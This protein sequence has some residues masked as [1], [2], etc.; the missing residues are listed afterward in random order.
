MVIKNFHGCT[1]YYVNK[2]N[3]IL[4][5]STFFFSQAGEEAQIF[6]V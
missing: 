2:T 1:K 6:F 5:Q 4:K 3:M